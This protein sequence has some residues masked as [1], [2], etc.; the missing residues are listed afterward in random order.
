MP[1]KDPDKNREYQRAWQRKNR[2]APRKYR[3]G[4][5]IRAIEALGGTCVYCGCDDFEALEFNHK[6]G[7]GYQEKNGH[8]SKSFLLS[9]IRNERDDIEVTCRIC[10]AYHY[11]KLIKGI[12]GSWNIDW[13]PPSNDFSA[14]GTDTGVL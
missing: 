11:L 6:N 2:E 7:G 8:R 12:E 5:R 3:K 10:N 14:I 4:L 1:I 9:I 13:K